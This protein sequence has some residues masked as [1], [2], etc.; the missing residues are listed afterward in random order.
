MT[1]LA[2]PLGI[3]LSTATRA[4]DKLVAKGLVER[5]RPRRDRRLVLVG[6]SGRGK[7]IN[8]FVARSRTAI[9]RLLLLKLRPDEIAVLMRRLGRL[10]GPG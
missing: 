2:G 3:P 10:S 9:A 6:F 1:E 4:I 8:Q 7:E 5:R